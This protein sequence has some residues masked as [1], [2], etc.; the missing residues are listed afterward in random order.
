MEGRISKAYC[1]GSNS[2][3]I[4]GAL[5]RTEKLNSTIDFHDVCYSKRRWKHRSCLHTLSSQKQPQFQQ[6]FCLRFMLLEKVSPEL[7]GFCRGQRYNSLICYTQEGS[8][9]QKPLE[10]ASSRKKMTPTVNI[11]R[12]K[13]A[14]T[15]RYEK[16]H[17]S[18]CHSP[19]NSSRRKEL[20]NTLSFV[21]HNPRISSC[22]STLCGL[23][24]CL[25]GQ[26][27]LVTHMVSLVGLRHSKPYFHAIR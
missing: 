7:K 11:H 25:M 12:K 22:Q 2:G 16:P 6:R 27:S 24:N 3:L 18:H 5:C 20:Y 1:Q 17:T 4:K 13:Q 21:L 14:D 10:F 19:K 23:S 15:D 8:L 26:K 9:A